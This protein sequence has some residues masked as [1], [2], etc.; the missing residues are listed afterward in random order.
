MHGRAVYK[1]VHV[2]DFKSNKKSCGAKQVVFQPWKK[3]MDYVAFV[4]F[5][6]PTFENVE[7]SA[8]THISPPSQGWANWE[9]CGVDFTCTGLYNVVVRIETATH[10]GDSKLPRTFNIISNNAESDSSNVLEKKGLCTFH[11][12]WNAYE[13]KDKFG[14]LIFDSR[15]ADRMDRSAQP[16]YIK[17]EDICTNDQTPLC[18]N[19]RLNAFGDHCWDGFYTCQERE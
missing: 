3:Q 7:D 8:L 1:N 5:K 2:K 11:K 16:I 13:C 14:V 19:N 15:D 9:D 6:T 17:N 4:E 10:I 12:D 18:F